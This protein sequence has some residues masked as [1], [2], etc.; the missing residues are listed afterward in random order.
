M[1][2]RVSETKLRRLMEQQQRGPTWVMQ[3]LAE[4][5]VV[6]SLS[7]VHRWSTGERTIPAHAYPALAT[8]FHVRQKDLRDE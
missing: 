2:V 8:I 3:R 5:G 7:A 1:A 4:H 6:A